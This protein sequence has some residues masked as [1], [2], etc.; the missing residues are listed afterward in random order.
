MF[1]ANGLKKIS[2]PFFF[3]IST[4]CEVQ[5]D[6]IITHNDFIDVIPFLLQH[7]PVPS[8]MI[9]WHGINENNGGA[10]DP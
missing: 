6:I 7:D 3:K 1:Y 8:H 5:G 4:G 10:N 9:S 2:K